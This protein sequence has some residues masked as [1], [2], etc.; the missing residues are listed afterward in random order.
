MAIVITITALLAIIVG[1]IIMIWPK[2]INYAIGIWLILYGLLQ[3]L[4][5]YNL[6]A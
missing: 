1:V 6:V 3:M 2:I 4:G 5:N